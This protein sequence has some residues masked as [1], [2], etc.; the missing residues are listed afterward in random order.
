MLGAAANTAQRCC[1]Q[2]ASTDA[3]AA[4]RACARKGTRSTQNPTSLIWSAGTSNA[5][6]NGT[7]CC[8]VCP[9]CNALNVLQR[10]VGRHVECDAERPEWFGGSGH[11]DLPANHGTVSTQEYGLEGGEDTG[12]ERAEPSALVVE[13]DR[14]VG[15]RGSCCGCVCGRGERATG[16]GEGGR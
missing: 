14:R 8:K 6:R 7:A 9:D 13:C 3:H 5:M 2:D 1:T 16:K 15:S 11:N 4:V 12:V 10:L